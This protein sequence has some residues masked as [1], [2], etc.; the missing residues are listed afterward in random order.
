[1]VA[2]CM[3]SERQAGPN[4]FLVRNYRVPDRSC[5][6][7][8]RDGG[9][10][11]DR[12]PRRAL[13][14]GRSP[15][16]G[17]DSMATPESHPSWGHWRVWLKG[18]VESGLLDRLPPQFDPDGSGHPRNVDGYARRLLARLR[19]PN[20]DSRPP[21]E[22]LAELGRFRSWV[23]SRRSVSRRIILA[24]GQSPDAASLERESGSRPPTSAKR[25]Q[26]PPA[27]RS[28]RPR[29]DPMWDDWLDGASS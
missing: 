2:S 15:Y 5:S 28:T 29:S 17:V 24:E 10:G 6:G 13:L 12:L 7:N 18:T 27:P 21:R 9:R 22:L 8:R 4:R 11:G 20:S 25:E 3:P 14:R 16:R 23:E 19:D 1:M 26:R